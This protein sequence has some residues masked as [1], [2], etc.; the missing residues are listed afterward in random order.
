M[1]RNYTSLIN[2]IEDKRNKAH[3]GG[4]E[5]R[6]NNYDGGCQLSNKNPDTI[7]CRVPNCICPFVL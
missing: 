3:L 2:R 1:T 7:H 6:I 4:G 5:A